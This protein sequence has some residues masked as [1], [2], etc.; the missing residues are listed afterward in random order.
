MKQNTLKAPIIT[1][2][3]IGLAN[4]ENVYTFEVATEANKNQIAA[5][6]EQ[7]YDVTVLRVR[8]MIMPRRRKRSPRK[9]VQ[10][11]NTVTKKAL[12]KLEAGQTIDL[13]DIGGNE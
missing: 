13:F 8:T 2:K 9:R 12:V 6:I 10:V 1:E 5:A 7:L 11:Q 3:S 4:S